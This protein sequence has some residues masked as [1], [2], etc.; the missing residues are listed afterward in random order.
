MTTQQL[1][2]A[3]A[4]ARSGYALNT[5]L[6]LFD[7]FG[8]PNFEPVTCTMEALASLVR[9]QCVRFDGSI[10]QEALNEIARVG[11]HRFRVVGGAAVQP[12]RIRSIAEAKAER[13]TAS[14]GIPRF[15]IA[16][17]FCPPNIPN[18]AI[19][20]HIVTAANLNSIVGTIIYET[21]GTKR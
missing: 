1:S 15:V 4:L 16:E 9:W 13:L 20:F 2:D 10:D 17:G 7:G 21:K 3:V 12:I 11:R 6:S 19:N 18:C 5:D 14:D 8:L